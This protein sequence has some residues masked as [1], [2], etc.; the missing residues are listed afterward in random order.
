MV[1]IAYFASNRSAVGNHT[2]NQN[3]DLCT[4]LF[5]GLEKFHNQKV[6]ALNREKLEN[7][8]DLVQQQLDMKAENTKRQIQVQSNALEV[9]KEQLRLA[10]RVYQQTELKFQQGTIG[11]NDLI[12]ADNSL[13]QAQTNVVAAY[14]QLRQAELEYL[15]TIGNIK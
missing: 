12:I 2:G 3:A 9:S 6:N 14:I 1:E 13:Q 8:K 4:S 10:E 11:S 15:K 5:D 7:Q